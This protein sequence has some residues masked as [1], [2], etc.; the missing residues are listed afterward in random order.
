MGIRHVGATVAKEITARF[1]SIDSLASAVE[2]DLLDIEG[3]GPRI[4]ESVVFFF[5]QEENLAVIGKLRRGGVRMADDAGPPPTET[6]FA[7]R[8]FVLTGS[9]QDFTREEASAIIEGLGGRVSSSVSGKTDFVLA[10]ADPGSKLDR[11]RDLGVT[12]IDE[13]EFK[14]MAG[15]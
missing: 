11:A 15:R 3:I 12:I 2:E 7:G 4:G 1:P 8:T 10:G 14:R 5:N 9:L 6:P 13:K